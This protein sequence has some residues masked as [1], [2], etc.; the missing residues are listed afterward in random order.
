MALSLTHPQE[1]PM[2]PPVNLLKQKLSRREFTPGCWLT[3]G[4]PAVA[5]A[6]AHCGFDWL[7]IDAEHGPNDVQDVLAQLQAIDAA[8]GNGAVVQAVVR[9]PWNDA[10]L[11]KRVMD[12]GAQSVMFP[13]VESAVE[14]ARAVAA[15]RYPQDGNGGVRG[16]AGIV[17]AG[18]YGLDRDYVGGANREAC[19]LVQIETARGVENVGEI[20]ATEGVDCLFVGPAD[21][22][23]SMGHLGDSAH[24]EV[25]GAIAR[26]N[27]V[28]AQAGKACGIFAADA[29]SAK[30]HGAA[31]MH[32]VALGADGVLLVRAARAALA[33][34]T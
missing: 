4:S 7:L 15:T 16:V 6:L 1:M 28:C 34:L 32:F 11:V 3:L 9:V 25:Q 5:E 12:C 14:A 18:R 20:A 22:A 13:A 24:P 31:G 17:R 8:R 21:L 23:A 27:A 19:V 10:V 29:E 2:P 26:V 33:V 30:R